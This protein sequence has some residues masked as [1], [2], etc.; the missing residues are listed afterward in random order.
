MRDRTKKLEEL[1]AFLEETIEDGIREQLERYRRAGVNTITRGVID[2]VF[3]QTK[4]NLLKHQDQLEEDG[5]YG[6]VA[7]AEFS[8]LA[9]TQSDPGGVAESPPQRAG[10]RHW[11]ESQCTTWP[12]AVLPPPEGLSQP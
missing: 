10:V 6:T 11:V 3:E 12:T 8:S 9:K 2:Q 4:E 5:L 7:I 1:Q